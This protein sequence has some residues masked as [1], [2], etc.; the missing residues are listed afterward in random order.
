MPGQAM[1]TPIVMKKLEKVMFSQ[2]QIWLI[3]TKGFEHAW[4]EGHLIE[5]VGVKKESDEGLSEETTVKFV[6]LFL[7]FDW[8]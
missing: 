7:N 8:S 3:L 6:T 1:L 5:K 4:R 2:E